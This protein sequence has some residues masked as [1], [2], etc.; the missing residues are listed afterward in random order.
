[1]KVAIFKLVLL[2]RSVPQVI[3]ITARIAQDSL[4]AFCNLEH[5]MFELFS[6]IRIVVLARSGT[7]YRSSL[8]T[9]H[10]TS[11]ILQI[12]NLIYSLSV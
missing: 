3:I 1:M 10:E 7:S 9:Q 2:F 4:I 11:S 8:S 5:S 6:R 12:S